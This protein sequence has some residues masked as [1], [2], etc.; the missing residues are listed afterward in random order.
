MD[1][2]LRGRKYSLETIRDTQI[3]PLA[4]IFGSGPYP[5]D[6]SPEFQA[7]IE[8]IVLS[9]VIDPVKQGIFAYVLINLFPDLDPGIARYRVQREGENYHSVGFLSIDVDEFK[10]LM[11]LIAPLMEEKQKAKDLAKPPAKVLPKSASRKG[12]ANLPEST[13]KGD[14][15]EATEEATEIENLKARL[16]ELEAATA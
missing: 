12:F 1:L 7:W 2:T 16:R 4:S 11:L 3:T 9:I 13:P 5:E 6:G 8:Q 14:E 10:A 15:P